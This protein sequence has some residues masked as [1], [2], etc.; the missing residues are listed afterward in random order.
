MVGDVDVNTGAAN[1]LHDFLAGINLSIDTFPLIVAVA[2]PPASTGSAV[3]TAV[4]D[5]SEFKTN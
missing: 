4:P 1:N 2:I 5:E 3:T